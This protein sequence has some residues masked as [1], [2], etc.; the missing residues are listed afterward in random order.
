MNWFRQTNSWHWLLIGM[1]GCQIL[2]ALF[3]FLVWN[4]VPEKNDPEVL[5][6]LQAMETR[7]MDLKLL[8]EEDANLLEVEAANIQKRMNS[9]E[10][11]VRQKVGEPIPEG[12]QSVLMLGNEINR[13]LL[14]HQL[15]IIEQEQ[16][17][18]K[19]TNKPTVSAVAIDRPEVRAAMQAAAAT[20]E[21]D[22]KGMPGLPFNTR[23]VRYV[24]EGEYKQMFM[25]LIRQS[26]LK[27]SYHFKDIKI[28]P[29]SGPTG[30]RME[31]TAQIHFTES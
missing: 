4:K 10:A 27:P 1:V 20:A 6:K 5:D 3:C 25:F 31:F 8:Q 2:A 13:E 11:V 26:H 9:Y 24:L 14:K 22:E 15:R 23:E 28:T 18:A 29:A 16:V 17:E 30:M 21:G 7:L 19:V 12:E